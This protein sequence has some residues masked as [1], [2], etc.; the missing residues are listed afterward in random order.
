VNILLIE[1][2]KTLRKLIGSYIESAGH[3][4]LKAESG[5][6][7][8]QVLE[9][10]TVDLIVTDVDMPGLGGFETV[11]LMREILGEHWMPI[12]ILTSRN[13]DAD[14][15]EGFEAGA[16]DYLIKPVREVVLHSKIHVM[17]RFITM[18]NELEETINAPKPPT[19]FDPLTR[20]YTDLAFK[21]MATLQWRVLARREEPACFIMV[22]I[23][24]NQEYRDRYGPEKAERCTVAVARAIRHSVHR[25]NDFVGRL[26]DNIFVVMLPYTIELGANVVAQRISSDVDALNIE[27]KVSPKSG[28]VSVTVSGMLSLFVAEHNLEDNVERLR[29]VHRARTRKQKSLAKCIQPFD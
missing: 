9:D 18:R 26:D 1:D 13:D 10:N 20:C 28:G 12:I 24:F 17:E 11:Q 19:Q 23:D 6:I 15:K 14:F 16:D 4:L 3:T 22:S 7:A 21:E 25:P 29:K 2:S 5:E 8:M 27:H